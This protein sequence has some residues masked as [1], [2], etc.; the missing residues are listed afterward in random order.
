M[1]KLGGGL[2]GRQGFFFTSSFKKPCTSLAISAVPLCIHETTCA[3]T[4]FLF[5]HP[6]C[7]SIDLSSR[8]CSGLCWHDLMWHCYASVQEKQPWNSVTP[9]P[10]AP[11]CCP[12]AIQYILNITAESCHGL[13]QGKDSNVLSLQ[14]PVRAHSHHGMDQSHCLLRKF[15]QDCDYPN[16]LQWNGGKKEET[17][18]VQ[19]LGSEPGLSP[20]APAQPPGSCR[21]AEPEE[22]TACPPPCPSAAGLLQMEKNKNMLHPPSSYIILI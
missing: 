14:S 20:E 6:L 19:W 1:A 7:V 21:P 15:L 11:Y 2:G 22:L 12:G 16:L 9:H 4:H 5:I 18:Q 17:Q 13:V 10:L 8:T 3:S